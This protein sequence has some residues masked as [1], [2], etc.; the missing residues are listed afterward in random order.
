MAKVLIVEDDADTARLLGIQLK[1][2]GYETAYASDAV[3][4]MTIA[5]KEQPD[6]IVLDLGLPGGDGH[7]VMERLRA[8]PALASTPVVVVSARDREANEE[9]V[10]AAGASAFVEKPF[11]ADRLIAAVAAALE[12]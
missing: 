11:D 9:R 1:R 10:V 5:R 7:I 8:M 2:A 3:T 4:T 6:V 12:P